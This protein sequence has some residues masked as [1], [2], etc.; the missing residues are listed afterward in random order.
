MPTGR[1]LKL[2]ITDVDPVT[3]CR[4]CRTHITDDRHIVSRAF[5]GTTGRATL[6]SRVLNIRLAAIE[7]EDEELEEQGGLRGVKRQM[8]TGLH[9]VLDAH[10]S[11]C[12]T[13]LGW[14]YV[15]AEEADQRYKE[16]KWCIERALVIDQKTDLTDTDFQGGNF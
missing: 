1:R 7:S 6:Y 11:T 5:Q 8:T 10:C 3:C 9:E 14:Y 15:T 16:G 4:K 13:I 12:G 2:F